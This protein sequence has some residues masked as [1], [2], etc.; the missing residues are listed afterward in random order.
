MMRQLL[1]AIEKIEEI[2]RRGWEQDHRVKY[3]EH[4]VEPLFDF[5]RLMYEATELEYQDRLELIGIDDIK[6][7]NLTEVESCRF[8][9][10]RQFNNLRASKREQK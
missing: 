9:T 10:D 3:M 8:M 6:K 1:Y 2:D 7:Y 5:V 4:R